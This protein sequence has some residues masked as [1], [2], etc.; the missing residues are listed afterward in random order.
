MRFL[1]FFRARLAC[2]RFTAILGTSL[3]AFSFAFWYYSGGVEAYII[4]VFFLWLALYTLTADHVPAKAFLLVGFLNATA[5]PTAEMF[6]LFATVVLLAA[7]HSHRRGDCSLRRSLAC[8]IGVAVPTVAIPYL[9]AILYVGRGSLH[10]SWHWLTLYAHRARF[11]NVPSASALMKAAI[12]LGQAFIGSHS[13]LH[14]L[15][16]GR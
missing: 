5:D 10:G 15:V 9:S 3:P 1:Q 8:Y 11:W 2:D 12:G 14:F 13:L 4:P 6:V 16:C 7:W